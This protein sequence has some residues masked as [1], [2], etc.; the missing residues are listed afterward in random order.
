MWARNL[1]Y[2]SNGKILSIH[3]NT[4]VD[5]YENRFLWIWTK[6]GSCLLCLRVCLFNLYFFPGDL[7][8]RN[9]GWRIECTTGEQSGHCLWWYPRPIPWLDEAFSDRWSCSSDKLHFY[10]KISLPES[11]WYLGCLFCMIISHTLLIW[12]TRVTLLI[13]A[14]IA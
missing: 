2:I 4:W 8:Q 5:L 3:L 12:C 10:G 1:F 7:G 6:I 14:I 13:V 11:L 9:T